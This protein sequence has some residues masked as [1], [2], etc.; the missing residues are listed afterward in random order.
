MYFSHAT[1]DTHLL[2]LQVCPIP[3]KSLVS[4]LPLWVFPKQTGSC[5]QVKEERENSSPVFFC[6]NSFLQTA[7]PG[8]LYNVCSS[9]RLSL[10]PF[11][12]FQVSLFLPVR[13]IC[14]PPK[15]E[16]IFSSE[17]SSFSTFLKYCCKS[18]VFQTNSKEMGSFSVL[19]QFMFCLIYTQ[20]AL[21]ASFVLPQEEASE[22]ASFV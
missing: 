6:L 8:K 17:R 22:T 7:A 13:H 18:S 10:T 19:Q 3:P 2:L 4:L 11:F 12:I 21:S 15:A 9:S 5:Y 16:V 20:K 14:Q 1:A